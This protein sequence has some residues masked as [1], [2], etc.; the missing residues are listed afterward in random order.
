M[1]LTEYTPSYFQLAHEQ[2][3]TIARCTLRRLTEEENLE[4]VGHELFSLVDQY[5]RRKIV[6]DLETV[7][8]LTSAALGKFITLHRKLH[9]HQGRLILCR[10]VPQVKEVM[11]LSRLIDYFTTAA[12]VPAAMIELQ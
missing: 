10:L 2:D 11:R 12:D 9:R 5:D 8:F 4:E 6:L 1:S 7:E 3:V